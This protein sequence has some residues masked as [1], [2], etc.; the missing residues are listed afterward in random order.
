[1]QIEQ[2]DTGLKGQ[3]NV[4]KI[5]ITPEENYNCKQVVRKYLTKIVNDGISKIDH[6]SISPRSL[7]ILITA[8]RCLSCLLPDKISSP[9]TIIPIF[10]FNFKANV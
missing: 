4:E 2:F 8:L 1:M 6:S 9:I 5:V 10:F 7:K 3:E